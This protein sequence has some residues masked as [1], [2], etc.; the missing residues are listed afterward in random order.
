MGNLGFLQN[1]TVSVLMT[2]I[3]INARELQ[4]GHLGEGS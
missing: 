2:D 3:T 4:P 1:L